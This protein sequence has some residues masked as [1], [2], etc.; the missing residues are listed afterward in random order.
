[1]EMTEYKLRRIWL[2]MKIQKYKIYTF[3]DWTHQN[4]YPEQY[5]F[6]LHYQILF[7]TLSL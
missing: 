7:D 6:Y 5:N 4:I 1:M 3:K 2:L